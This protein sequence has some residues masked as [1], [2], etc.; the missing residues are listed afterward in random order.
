[1]SSIQAESL[2]LARELSNYLQ[3]V[4]IDE[5]LQQRVEEKI[6]SIFNFCRKYNVKPENLESESETWLQK[7][8][9]V[10]GYVG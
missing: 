2:E 10:K 9:G 1:M 3:N 7:I 6:Q 5:N 4:D 8:R